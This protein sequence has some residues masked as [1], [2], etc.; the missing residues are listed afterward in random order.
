ML[1]DNLEDVNWKQ[2][3][4]VPGGDSAQKQMA[5]LLVFVRFRLLKS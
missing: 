2:Y 1:K 4:E 3:L 5:D